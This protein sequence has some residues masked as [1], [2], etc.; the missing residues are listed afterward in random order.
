MPF[1]VILLLLLLLFLI[2]ILLLILLFRPRR[3]DVLRRRY[4][5][6]LRRETG[7][8]DPSVRG[9]V[10]AAVAGCP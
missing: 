1:I 5:L 9:T 4:R 7:N 6:R 10:D 3:P 2:L 8:F